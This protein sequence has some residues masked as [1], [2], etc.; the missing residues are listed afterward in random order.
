MFVFLK[1]TGILCQALPCNQRWPWK[2][3]IWKGKEKEVLSMFSSIQL[4]A[5][6]SHCASVCVFSC[7][8]HNTIYPLHATSVALCCVRWT[9]FFIVLIFIQKVGVK[10]GRGHQVACST[11]KK[12]IPWHREDLDSSKGTSLPFCLHKVQNQSLWGF[13]L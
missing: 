1:L 8:Y 3:R 7:F 11:A 4:Y 6:A 12:I 9:D 10:A 5:L 2:T 13:Y